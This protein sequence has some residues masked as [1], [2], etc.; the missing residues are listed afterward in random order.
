MRKGTTPTF[1]FNILDLDLS[2]ATV[3]WVIFKQGTI[4]IKKTTD[5]LTID[6]QKI[7]VEFTQ[8]ETLKFDK[9]LSLK[10]QIRVLTNSEK[11]YASNIFDI[12]V[13]DLLV[14]EVIS[15]N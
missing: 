9:N 13:N 3:V 12:S 2:T 8:E 15:E 10:A 11:A 1:T 14:K 5:D 7:I 6:E 4:V